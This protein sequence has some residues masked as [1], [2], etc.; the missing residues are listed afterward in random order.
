MTAKYPFFIRS[1]VVL[2]GFILLL[3]ALA[4]SG[5]IIIPL[6]FAG[7]LA[8]LLNPMYTWLA[9]KKIPKVLSIII[10]LLI[11]IF[12]FGGIG[13]FVSSQLA[14]FTTEMPLL[15]EKC[16]SL[17]A[18]LQ[19]EIDV[20]LGVD[21][22]KQNEWL[23]GA[24]SKLEPLAGSALSGLFGS[25]SVLFLLPVY[26]FLFLYYK[27][28]LLNFLYEVFAEENTKEVGLV[29]TQTKQAI[30][31]F[32]SGLLLEALIVAIL[33]AA[34]LL[35]LGVKYAILIGVIGA[36]LNIL[37]YIGGI[38][39]IA[40]PLLIATITKDGFH[41]QLWIL[42]SYLI[43]QFIDNNILMP[44]IVSSKVKINALISIIMILMGGALWGISGMF[45]SIPFTGI[46][47]I[48]FDRITELKPWGKLL[49]T[50]IPTRHAGMLRR[51]RVKV[52]VAA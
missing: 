3:Y 13:Y 29:L 35:L 5:D 19:H 50:E 41:T 38:I 20:R 17:F 23:A 33:D 30:Q 16:I 9:N 15:K 39:A 44:Y 43:I 32:M 11:A 10:C 42:F 45:L 36:L 52:E 1:T 24:Q 49:G 6:A 2:F 37:P 25:L 26:T 18:K 34:A 51:K 14:S 8:I 40:I 22:Q 48:I 12:V 21:I 47:K 31:R 7:M 4:Q 27:T 28:L 46:L